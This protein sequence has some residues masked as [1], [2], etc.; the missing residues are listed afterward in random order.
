[1]HHSIAWRMQLN[2]F[3]MLKTC[4]N[5]SMLAP[6]SDI[7]IL[8]QL[9]TS[10]RWRTDQISYAFSN[11]ASEI[12]ADN[13]ESAAFSRLND[14][15]KVFLTKSIGAWDELVMPDFIRV[16]PGGSSLIEYGQTTSGIEYA[17]AYQPL[18]GSV[19]FNAS[20][21]SLTSP[22]MG[23][24]GYLTYMHETGHALGLDHMGDYNGV[25]NWQPSSWQDSLVYSIMSYF[26][27]GAAF[28]GEGDVAWADWIGLDGER[29]YPQTPMLNDVMAIQNM[30]GIE[31]TRAEN[32]IYGFNANVS[33]LDAFTFDFTRNSN[34]IICIYDTAGIDTLDL[35]GWAAD[36]T[37]DLMGGD[38]H[39][40]SCNGM[41]NN[42][43][44]ARG[45]QIE[46]GLT[47]AGNDRL[48]GNALANRLIGA[49]GNDVFQGYEGNDTL[50]GG[51][52]VDTLI[53]EGSSAEYDVEFNR[54]TG[55]YQLTHRIN[56]ELDAFS[57]IEFLQFSDRLIATSSLMTDAVYRFFNTQNGVHF[58]TGSTVE[59]EQ[60]RNTLHKFTFE[61]VAF[62][63]NSSMLNNMVDVFRF[64]NTKTGAHLYTASTEE[65]NAI[66][67]SLPEFLDEGVAYTAYE[68][69]EDDLS[70]LYRFF[71][72][73]TGTHFCTANSLEKQ[74]VELILSGQ[75]HYEGIAYYVAL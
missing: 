61:G 34:P 2:L 20:E 52:G 3:L 1:M 42:I 75:M 68:R 6:W 47:G 27:P 24:Y 7:E 71:N 51:S 19:W 4:T 46:N 49:D 26:G 9:V 67:G 38:H 23:S 31:T 63:T 58:Y 37:L 45:V 36:A 65:A 72:V 15:Q 50:E 74:Q 10:E 32:T 66:R 11:R 70:P 59:A 57:N 56:L 33:D 73:Q 62:H 43:Q 54:E 30:Y 13:G 17:H 40:I 8:R 14:Q 53:L 28:D 60:V 69:E 22:D 29:Y 5:W 12:Y 35:S 39:F 21:Q 64:F 18:I 44:I 16:E 48:I 25:G 55:W 41:T